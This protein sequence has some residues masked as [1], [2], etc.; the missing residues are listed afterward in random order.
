MSQSETSLKSYYV[1][2]PVMAKVLINCYRSYSN[3]FVEG[4]STTIHSCEGTAQ[5][6]PLAMAMFGLA[7]IPLLYKVKTEDTGQ[8]W[9]ADDAGCG[10]IP[11]GIRK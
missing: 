1:V 2:S 4:T 9:F 7:S 6:D 3:L 8:L 11:L 10:G 5:G